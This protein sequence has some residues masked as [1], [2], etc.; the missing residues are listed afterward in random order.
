[1]LTQFFVTLPADVQRAKES[2]LSQKP[3][4]ITGLTPSGAVKVFT[5]P[6]Q[7]VEER[8]DGPDHKRWSV[9]IHDPA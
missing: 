6:V 3:V 7:A 5:G 2:L 4:T 1:M 8:E 9:T